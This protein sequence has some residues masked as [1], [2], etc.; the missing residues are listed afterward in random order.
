MFEKDCLF[1]DATVLNGCVMHEH[2]CRSWEM[3]SEEWDEAVEEEYL[4]EI[5]GD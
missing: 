5:Q 1:C 4:K 2:D 3:N